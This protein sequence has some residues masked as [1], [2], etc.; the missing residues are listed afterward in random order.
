[1][2]QSRHFVRSYSRRTYAASLC[3]EEFLRLIEQEA[4][5]CRAARHGPLNWFL[6]LF[7][8]RRSGQPIMGYE[9]KRLIDIAGEPLE[10]EFRDEDVYFL[11]DTVVDAM[12]ERASHQSSA[13]AS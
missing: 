6:N 8:D 13:E 12:L 9:I 7:R 1:M 10:R 2:E 11:S 3:D 5:S 4:A